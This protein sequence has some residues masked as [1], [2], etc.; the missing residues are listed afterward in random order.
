MSSNRRKGVT[1]VE[2]CVV[3]AILV[4]VFS[5]LAPALAG[6]KRAA[7]KS[8]SVQNLRQIG[9]SL[10]LYRED[11][12][13]FPREY[14]DPLVDA[15]YLKETSLLVSTCDVVERGYGSEMARCTDGRKPPHWKSSFETALFDPHFLSALK[16]IDEEAAIVVDRTCGSRLPSVRTCDEM[17][18]FYW[19]SIVRLRE[20]TS[21]KIGKFWFDEVPGESNRAWRRLRLFTE[22]ELPPLS[23]PNH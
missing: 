18:Y 4:V 22:R 23:L 6:S 7:H 8:R 11:A 14:F 16:A 3:V 20:D 5:I 19:G 1:L 15:G 12:G 21:V 17:P 10:L 9:V 13:D 2:V